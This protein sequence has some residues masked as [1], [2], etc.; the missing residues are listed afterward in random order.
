[1]YGVVMLEVYTLLLVIVMRDDEQ[2]GDGATLDTP[3]A[4][5]HCRICSLSPWIALVLL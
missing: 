1:M 5:D 3:R 4:E 2:N